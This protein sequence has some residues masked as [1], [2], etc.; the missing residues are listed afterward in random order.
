[1]V[2]AV[3]FTIALP[4]GSGGET[5]MAKII[6]F[7]SNGSKKS[8]GVMQAMRRLWAVSIP[9]TA[10]LSGTMAVAFAIAV[11]G[12]SSG[13][14]KT[15]VSSSTNT[16]G[17]SKSLPTPTPSLVN[18]T[19]KDKLTT[20]KKSPV[21]H[22]SV[23]YLDSGSGV[24][25]RYPREYMLTTPQKVKLNSELLDR[26]PMNFVEPGGVKVATVALPGKLATPLLGVN[27]HKGLTAG[28][29]EQFANPDAADVAA[30]SKSDPDDES[31]PVKV[32]MRGRDF[33]RVETGNE[34]TD[35]RYYHHFENG[36]CYE[37]VL[38]VAES[39]DNKI[40]VDHFEMFDNLERILASLEIKSGAPTSVTASVPATPANQ[41]KPQ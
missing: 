25:F 27:V 41:N 3:P 31:I 21:Q 5:N 28:Q 33:I 39:P 18:T 30:S 29:C 32:S 11:D 20:R 19:D 36:A 22:S 26:V 17:V 40:A 16:S 13:S 35:T 12:C 10:V 2:A 38:A 23:A 8:G 15:D 14:K 24:S 9:T 1:M 7:D 37:F 34:Q 6:S 4:V